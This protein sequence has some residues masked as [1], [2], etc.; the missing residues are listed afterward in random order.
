MMVC[1]RGKNRRSLSSYLR[2]LL[3]I[4][5]GTGRRISA[6][7]ALR[8][9]DLKLNDGPHGSVLWPADTDKMKKAW[10]VPISGDVRA[11]INAVLAERPGIGAGFL[12]P[13]PADPSRPISI[14]N[15]SEWLVEAEKLAEVEKHDGSL[16]HALRRKWACER[17]GL[18]LS[19]VAAAGGWSDTSTLLNVYQQADQETM[20]R[21][22]S[23]PSKLVERGGRG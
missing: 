12:F 8:Y 16:W 7:L 23:E 10:L 3:S 1:G 21:V 20:Y 4:A 5:N 11:A 18:P 19:D 2:A 22:V 13:D 15:A 6:I 9:H 14:E 17:K